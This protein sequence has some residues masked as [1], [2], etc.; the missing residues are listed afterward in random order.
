MRRTVRRLLTATLAAGLGGAALMTLA[1]ASAGVQR[2]SAGPGQLSSPQLIAEGRQL[3]QEGCASCHGL[4]AGG[5]PGKAPDLHRAGAG[6]ADFYLSTGRMPLDNPG[7]Q[8]VRTKPRYSGQRID[9]LVAYIGSLGGPPIPK[10][11]PSLGNL[12]QGMQAFTDHCAG[13]HQ[14]AARGGIVTGAFA[15]S[16]VDATPTQVAEAVRVGPYVMPKFNRRLI[17]DRTLNSIARYVQLTQNPVD[18]GGWG[19]GHIGPVPEGMVAWLMGLAAVLLVARL[20]G[21]RTE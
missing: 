2:L 12:S 18:E 9:A 19:I 15:P 20:I 17:D 4:D 6:A 10:V 11:D 14:V 1:N 5:I 13:C 8:P 16:L 21:E 3:Y 7:D